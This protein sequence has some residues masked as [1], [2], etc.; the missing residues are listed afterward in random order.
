MS[1][2]LSSRVVALCGLT[3]SISA[4]N[5]MRY[6]CK[7]KVKWNRTETEST[8]A[9][10]AECWFWHTHSVVHFFHCAYM[11]YTPTHDENICRLYKRFEPK[12]TDS[13]YFSLQ[14]TFSVHLAN[15]I[16]L[17]LSFSPSLERGNKILTEH[18]HEHIIMFWWQL[19]FSV[20]GKWHLPKQISYFFTPTTFPKHIS[21]C[22]LVSLEMNDTSPASPSNEANNI[23]NA[24]SVE[25]ERIEKLSDG[26]VDDGDMYWEQNVKHFTHFCFISIFMINNENKNKIPT[27]AV[28]SFCNANGVD[29]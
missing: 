8:A 13:K 11:L 18:E 15:S 2:S 3:N 12:W 10:V 21:V 1:I 7:L 4:A 20:K 22:Q 16:S 23:H 6:E 28:S 26:H 25:R 5:V 29:Q 14:F 17:C 9:V 24:V 19:T 27:V